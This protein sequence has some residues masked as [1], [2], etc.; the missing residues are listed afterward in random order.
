MASPTSV[1]PYCSRLYTTLYKG[2][3]YQ[4][5]LPGWANGFFSPAIVQT[6]IGGAPVEHSFRFHFTSS[7]MV[8]ARCVPALMCGNTH[9]SIVSLDSTCWLHSLP[10][11]ARVK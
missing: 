2:A 11:K 7:Y 4:E 5:D 9:P 1:V 10:A 3:Y 8:I 6:K